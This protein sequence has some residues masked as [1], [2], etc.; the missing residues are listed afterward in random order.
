[1]VAISRK[2]RKWYACLLLSIASP[3]LT[4]SLVEVCSRKQQPCVSR[5]CSGTGPLMPLPRLASPL[6]RGHTSRFN[7]KDMSNKDSKHPIINPRRPI[8]AVDPAIAS[9]HPPFRGR[10][11]PAETPPRRFGS[12]P[13][14]EEVLGTTQGQDITIGRNTFRRLEGDGPWSLLS[15]SLSQT[16]NVFQEGQ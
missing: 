9:R 10:G 1:M 4:C 16:R 13:R 5:T 8:S 3:S 14:G 2:D 6:P 12:S 11:R 15:L 7:N